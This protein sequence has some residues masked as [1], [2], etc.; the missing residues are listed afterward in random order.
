MHEKCKLCGGLIHREVPK[1]AAEVSI[2]RRC[3]F[4][5]WSEIQALPPGKADKEMREIL[6]NQA[7]G[8]YGA[9]S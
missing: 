2:C 4:L 9:I 3:G 7:G 6:R 8:P 5:L 1:L